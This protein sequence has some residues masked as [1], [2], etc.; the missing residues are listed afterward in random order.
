MTDFSKFVRVNNQNNLPT[1]TLYAGGGDLLPAGT[2]P[3][4][5]IDV[6][7]NASDG[8]IRLFTKES[9]GHTDPS[10]LFSSTTAPTLGPS[11]PKYIA[12]DVNNNAGR[13]SIRDNGRDSIL[14]SGANGDMVLRDKNGTHSFGFHSGD[15]KASAGL[16]IGGIESD[17]PTTK[18]M[19]SGFLALRHGNG[20]E[21]V[22]LDGLNGN[23]YIKDSNN[24][25]A[26]S[27]IS[28]AFNSNI[29]GLFI[30]ATIADGEPK[31]GQVYI[32]DRKGN[33]SI[34]L[35]GATSKLTVRNQLG[36]D[37]I[38][39][40]GQKGDILLPNAD[41]AEEFDVSPSEKKSIEPG[42][43]MII[44]DDGKLQTIKRLTTRE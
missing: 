39:I 24:L 42:S 40:D 4:G 25:P 30:G 1:I 29:A 19:K 33:D 7:G 37:S 15:D 2:P 34:I 20:N 5:V 6:G 9:G 43:V 36:A 3:G 17:T 31:P 14:L 38:V 10:I 35:D 28:R 11:R 12:F 27:I 32:R 13:I 21:S 44:S 8:V 22:I 41:C 26:F 23:M 16:W 18:K